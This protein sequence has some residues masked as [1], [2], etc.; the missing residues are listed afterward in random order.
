MTESRLQRVASGDLRRLRIGDESA[1]AQYGYLSRFIPEG[2]RSHLK[3]STI[4]APYATQ[5]TAVTPPSD[6]EIA[7]TLSSGTRL[8][9]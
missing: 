5:E 6:V 3:E 1:E 4:A 7:A 9:K 2:M 8:H